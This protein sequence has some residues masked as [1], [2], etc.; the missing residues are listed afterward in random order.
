MSAT[1]TIKQMKKWYVMLSNDFHN[2]AVKRRELAEE[3]R[4]AMVSEK[5]NES[6]RYISTWFASLSMYYEQQEDQ[7][8]DNK[9][10]LELL[11]ATAD[12]IGRDKLREYE[13]VDAMREYFRNTPVPVHPYAKE[14]EELRLFHEKQYEEQK[15]YEK[16]QNQKKS[17]AR[18]GRR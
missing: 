8:D 10:L 1:W 17:T 7:S 6:R 18:K 15:Q 12:A 4:E 5:P 9:M 2:S 14:I 13:V 3:L 16:E 11:E